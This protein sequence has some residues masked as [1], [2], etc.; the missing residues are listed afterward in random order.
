M[1]YLMLLILFSIN[2]VAYSQF[3][4]D[5]YIDAD[6]G[7]FHLRNGKA[8]FQKTYNTP[9]SFEQLEKKLTSYNSPSGGFQVKKIE[10]NTMNGVLV[11][12]HLNWNHDQLKSK[13]IPL[14]I[15]YPANAAFEVEKV[16]SGYQVTVNNIWFSNSSSSKK[17]ENL[18]LESIIVGKK[19]VVLTKNK[20]I[21]LGLDMIDGN[22]QEIFRM[23]GSTKD[24]R[25]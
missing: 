13:K 20:K 7:S 23:V 14:F 11:N 1:K 19:G 21:L 4:R 2:I 15:K 5:P 24:I 12:Y 17:Q 9:I 16:A 18:T 10:G 8:Y 22:F 6:D 25:F 3:N